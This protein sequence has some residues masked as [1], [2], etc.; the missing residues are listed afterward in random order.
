MPLT[1]TL[2]SSMKSE[3]SS[4]QSENERVVFMNPTVE[5]SH[6]I[7]FAADPR[8]SGDS[9]KG[10]IT[11]AARRLGIGY[12]RAKSLWYAEARRVDASEMDRLRA[13]AAERQRKQEEAAVHAHRQLV[14]RISIIEARLAQI[15]PDFH[16]EAAAALRASA[17]GELRPSRPAYRTVAD[18]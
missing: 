18:D 14:D 13:V 10:A 17:G 3:K 6:L 11:R 1:M 8:P 5:A 15:D 9:V 2:E 7:R 12:E 4:H 16:S